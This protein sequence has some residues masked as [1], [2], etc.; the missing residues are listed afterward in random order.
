MIRYALCTPTRTFDLLAWSSD[1]HFAV[2][3]EVGFT[4][5]FE[6]FLSSPGLLVWIEL[7]FCLGC[8]TTQYLS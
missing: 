3:Y 8:A 7:V 4:L 6:A 5:P 1:G 2:F